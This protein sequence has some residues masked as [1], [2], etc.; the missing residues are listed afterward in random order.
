MKHSFIVYVKKTHAHVKLMN[1]E[2]KNRTEFVVSP[3]MAFM[4]EGR[5]NM[6]A[7][8]MHAIKKVFI[9]ERRVE[10]VSF[11]LYPHLPTPTIIYSVLTL[12]RACP[13]ACE[14]LGVCERE[15]F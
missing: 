13:Q 1:V 4:S 9:L 12:E 7:K 14:L 8:R 3:R 6:E 10:S 5:K 15:R 11:M 2:N